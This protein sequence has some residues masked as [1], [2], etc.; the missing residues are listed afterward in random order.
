MES[1]RELWRRA[2]RKPLSWVLAGLATLFVIGIGWGLPASDTWDNDGVAPRDF[3]VGVSQTFSRGPYDFAYLHLAPFHLAVLAVLT[4]PITAA[5]LV[6]APSLDPRAVVATITATSYMTANA[7]V[8]RT[9]NAAMALGIVWALAKIGEE[10]AGDS[11]APWVAAMCGTNAALVYYA[12]ATNLEVPYLFWSAL[13]LLALVRAVAR[14]EPRRLRTFAWL[15]ALAIASKDQAAGLLLLGAP[16]TLVAW[17]LADGWAREQRRTLA[18][19]AGVALLIAFAVILVADEIVINPAGFAARVRFLLG[20]ASQDHA[21]YAADW[22][23]RIAILA[24][25]VSHFG[26]FYPVVFA[27]FVLF[28]FVLA[29]RTARVI[30]AA[31]LAPLLF[32]LSFT[33]CIN[34]TARR[35]EQ[36]FLL[37]QMEFAGLYAGLAINVL[38][39]SSAAAFRR[40]IA[41]GVVA[42]V[43]G[44]AVFYAA[45]VDANLLLDPRYDAEAWMRS[46][47]APGDVIETY[48]R[49]TYLPRFPGGVRA[50]RV[51]PEPVGG[52]SPRADLI[53]VVDAYAGVTRR[54]P[55]FVV[56]PNGWAWAYL[57][58]NSAVPSGQIK[59]V[60]HAK[61]ESD[62][63][64][65]FFRSFV[66]GER[67]YRL[68]H[69]SSWTSRIWPK[70]LIHASTAE[71]VWIYER[72]D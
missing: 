70:Y 42:I 72:V 66:R 71:P 61:S 9:V 3:L 7:L 39:R 53:E 57:D 25:T 52:R 65:V 56:M 19:E 14:R 60:A 23:G 28:G 43:L 24:D 20:P 16:A 29:V 10:I 68:A 12:H 22:R 30:R 5:A 6:A 59:P 45:D 18:R 38:L 49:N 36:R 34:L 2:A 64:L 31:A 41:C 17:L 33:L 40:W 48:G 54:R 32:A 1:A 62:P 26:Q 55:R 15:G 4:L 35:T 63:E 11:A 21:E 58:P 44:C 69:E 67:G 47:A 50:V 37:P 51:G 8:A 46:H 13:A 27:P